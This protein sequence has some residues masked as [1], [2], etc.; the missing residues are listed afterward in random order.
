[1]LISAPTKLSVRY[2]SAGPERVVEDRAAE[3]PVVLDE[4]GVVDLV[5]R[6]HLVRDQDHRRELVDAAR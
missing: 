4:P 3:D 1:M 6:R 5:G 2:S